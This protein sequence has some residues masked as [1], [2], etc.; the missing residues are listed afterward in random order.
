MRSDLMKKGIERAPHRSLLKAMGYTDSEIE[1][2]IIGVANSANEIV[3]GHIHLH[4]IARAVKDGIRS[5]G[6]LPIEF[7]TIAVCDGLAMGHLGMKYSLCSR[8]LIADSVETMVMAHPF[9]GLVLIPNCDKSVPGMLMVALR[10]NIPAILISGGPMLAGY[11]QGEALDLIS[12]F[13]A[14][15]SFASGKI[16]EERLKLL[17]DNACPGYGSCSGMFTANSMNCLSEA[18]GMALPG[19]GT[20]PAVMAERKRLAKYAGVKIMELYQKNIRPR[21][22]AVLT[23]FKNAI[24]VE[25]ALGASTNTVLHLPAIAKEAKVELDL[26]LFNQI[27]KTT[28]NLCRLSPAGTFHLED[29]HRAGGIAAIMSELTRKNLINLKTMTVTGRTLG[30]NI[31]G[32]KVLNNEVIRPVEKPYSAE[33]GLAILKGNLAPEGAVVKQSAVA[34][35]MLEH[36]GAARVFESEEEA[37]V[38]IMKRKIRKGEILVI[39]YEGP[40]GGPGMREML[41]PTSAIAGIGLDKEVALLTDGRFSGGTRGAAIGHISPEAAEG[42]PIAIVHNGDLIEINI[43]K[44]ELNLKLTAE[45]IK[46]RLSLWKVHQPKIKE[47]YLARYSKQVSSANTGAV[48][49]E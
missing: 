32:A 9:D 41:S 27:S 33:G 36:T 14:V 25:M 11:F 17:E 10:L 18:L 30:E 15:G 16:T 35:E 28:P 4:E 1:K 26:E 38:A 7:S 47:G 31:R 13:E 45:E 19:N 44:R 23:A 34:S 21:D 29:L 24:R 49:K 42:G 22:I 48:L 37:M 40:K 2:P 5:A 12:V 3:P 43:P 6:G 39:R 46:K 8:E 20:I